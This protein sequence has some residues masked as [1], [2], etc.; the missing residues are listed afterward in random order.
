MNGVRP[1]LPNALLEAPFISVPTLVHRTTV[2]E[3]VRELC[4]SD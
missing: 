2:R 3:N 4:A 1:T